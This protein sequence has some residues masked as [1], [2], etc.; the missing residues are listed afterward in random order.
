LLGVAAAQWP[1]PDAANFS[2]RTSGYSDKSIGARPLATRDAG[3]RERL[4][5]CL[6]AATARERRNG[7]WM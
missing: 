5:R 6:G 7:K 3:F 1:A 4:H 2:G